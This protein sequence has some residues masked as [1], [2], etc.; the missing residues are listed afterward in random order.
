MNGTPDKR[1]PVFDVTHMED[2]TDTTLSAAEKAVE[3]AL[4][5]VQRIVRQG[6]AERLRSAA[7]LINT[8]NY[9]IQSQSGRQEWLASDVRAF[10]I[11]LN[12]IDEIGVVKP[13]NYE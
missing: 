8:F 2:E 3:Q 11:A 13:S 10:F 1:L 6:D 12:A 9:A 7:H 5:S 4:Q